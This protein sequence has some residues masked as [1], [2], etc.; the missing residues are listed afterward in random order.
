LF[1]LLTPEGDL[2]FAESD[3]L[4]ETYLKVRFESLERMTFFGKKSWHLNYRVQANDTP[5]IVGS[6]TVCDC[7]DNDHE[8]HSVEIEQAA[9]F[10]IR[11]KLTEPEARHVVNLLRVKNGRSAGMMRLG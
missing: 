4:I 10:V 11:R 3:V 5:E 7:I 2:P 6:Q 1:R 8:P 9:E